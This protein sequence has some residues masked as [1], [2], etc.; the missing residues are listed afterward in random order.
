LTP[1]HPY[2]KGE[3][4]EKSAGWVRPEEHPEGLLGKPCHVCGYK[5]GTDWL[6]REIPAEDLAKIIALFD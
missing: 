6:Y 5:Y 4:Q 3:T 2:I 1:P